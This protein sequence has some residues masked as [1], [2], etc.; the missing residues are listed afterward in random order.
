MTRHNETTRLLLID[1]HPWCGTGC[2]CAW[3][4]CPASP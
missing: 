4:P 2:A 1:D 3:K